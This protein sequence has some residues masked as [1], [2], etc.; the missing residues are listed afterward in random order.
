[1]P[2][3]VN[4]NGKKFTFPDGTPQAEIGLA[5]DAFFS[6]QTKQ[7]QPAPI[8]TSRLNIDQLNALERSQNLEA[9]AERTRQEGVQL[10]P[11]EGFLAGTAAKMGDV[12]R[13]I[14][15]VALPGQPF[16]DQNAEVR[17]RLKEANP[18]SFAVGEFTGGTVAT[19]PV[20]GFAGGIAKNV[21]GKTAAKFGL[22]RAAQVATIGGGAAEG[23]AVATQLEEDPLTGALI[24]GAASA[25][26]PVIL[27][28]GGEAFRKLT[29]RAATTGVFDESGEL[30]AQAIKELED[31]GIPL[32]T[33]SDEVNRVVQDTFQPEIDLAV[34]TRAA[35][36]EEF[37][38]GVE[39]RTSRLTKSPAAQAAEEQLV[40]T[41]TPAGQRVLQA[42]QDVQAGLQ[43][44]ARDKLLGDLNTDLVA[45]FDDAADDFN[46]GKVG[47]T[48]RI[49]LNDQKSAS[50]KAVDS[51]YTSARGLVG[52]GAD[53][54]TQGIR[55]VFELQ[56]NE[57]AP[58]DGLVKSVGRSLKEFGI[59]KEGDELFDEFK[60]SALRS[61][62]DL[63][64]DNAEALRKKL[65]QLKPT[66]PTD[67]R[68]LTQ[69]KN[70]LD[71]EVDSLINQF[72]EEAAA[73]TAFKEARQASAAFKQTFADK[74]FIG[75][76]LEIKRGAVTEAI[77]EE[78][79]LARINTASLQDLKNIKGV[80]LE[81]GN[82][83]S[84]QAW[85]E[86]KFGTI[87]DIL[88]KSVIKD[89]VG[90]PTLSGAKLNTALGKIGN[91]RLK[92]LLGNEKFGQLKR[93]Q[94]VLSDQTIPIRRAENPS[95]TSLSLSPVMGKISQL[96]AGSADMTA[97][98]VGSLIN[99]ASKKAAQRQA[100]AQAAKDIK[101]SFGHSGRAKA[102]K[103]Q[104]AIEDFF[105]GLAETAGVAGAVTGAL[106][107]RN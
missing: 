96:L 79:I 43:A 40:A 18:K 100:I 22:S 87:D 26:M 10:S 9:E 65:N 30:T 97:P 38:P 78:K 58:T 19:L 11:M 82:K 92:L 83:A 89:S 49:A 4:A 42:E 24:G 107:E 69:V 81:G 41:G 84:K 106:D 33:F 52:E 47:E 98:G 37:A 74:E 31:A 99:G 77:P 73:A 27:K 32:E 12:G 35:Q 102:F 80:L 44:G 51:L 50:K 13:F 17:A 15:N 72:P 76:L 85:D 34:Q 57:L 7:Q 59:I 45:R 75:K 29:G 21:I 68:F 103:A 66:E 23:A 20:G 25:V 90:N 55:D 28:A 56:A 95:G 54:P 6:N 3:T 8:D 70:S 5:V 105:T 104:K 62:K 60:L 94:Q 16:Q 1:M 46:L 36:L 14:G 86:I 64:L 93:F 63:T 61:T 53:I 91:E 71:G 48:V 39:P 88:R 67:I 2:I 101:G